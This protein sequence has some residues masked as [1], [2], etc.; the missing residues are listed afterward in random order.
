ARNRDA[1]LVVDALPF[2]QITGAEDAR[3]RPHARFVRFALFD[4]LVRRVARATHR[5]D[6]ECQPRAALRLAEVG[7]EMRVELD[8][9]GHHGEVR[10]V[11]DL[12]TGV[13]RVGVRGDA[14]DAVPVA[15]D[16]DIGPGCRTLHVDEP[17][18]VHDD[19]AGGDGGRPL[20]IERYRARLAALDVDD[21]QLIHRLI[22]D[23]AGVALPAWGVRALA[24]D[25]SRRS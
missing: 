16:L 4:R 11:H 19:P 21:S 14:D 17:A 3:A 22:E 12:R 20:E 15:R 24:R 25:V 8:E 6:A 1:H 9:P 10:G 5:R 13:S 2:H 23:V 18:G 7:L